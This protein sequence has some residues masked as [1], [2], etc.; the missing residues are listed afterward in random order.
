MI[1]DITRYPFSN[2]LTEVRKLINLGLPMML[3]S[4]AAVGI[5]VVDTVV[6][7]SAG[8]DDLAAVALGSSLFMTVYITLIGVMT[9]L[10]PTIAQLHGA[11]HKSNVGEA[12]RQGIW[13]SLVLG[14]VGMLVILSLITPLKNYVHFSDHTE[15]MLGDYIFYTALAMPAAMFHRAIYAYV[16]SLNRPKPIMWIS[17]LA[18]I[19]NIPLN[20]IFVYGKFGL[21]EM[22]G[23]GCGLAT[24]L[25]FIFNSLALAWYVCYDRYFSHFGLHHQFSKPN[26]ATQKQLW[27]LGWP[28]GLSYFLESSLFTAI[29]W[30]IAPLGADTVSA[31]QIVISI[32]SVIYM[33]P[34]SIGSAATVLIGFSIGKRHFARARYISGVALML[35]ILLSIFT[36]ITMIVLR[37]ELA[38]IYTNDIDV[39]A[40]AVNIIIFAAVYQLFDF[41]QCIA[42]YALRGYKITRIPMVI[43]AISFWLLGLIPGYFCAYTLNMGIYGFWTTLVFSLIIASI[44]LVWY[45]EKCSQWAVTHRGL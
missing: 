39:I 28:I 29:V 24:L 4:I 42:S 34:Q 25:V 7:G 2:L 12:G 26:L 45:L 37:N 23:A 11:G 1:L 14:I 10:N 43:H 9:S 31:Q 22:G 27:R 8:K 6:A 16:S 40:I 19:L 32:S 20:Y 13:F 18:L 33:I 44:A 38:S 35:G 36:I 30:L 17:W 3:A 41:S 5:G 15:N 21:P